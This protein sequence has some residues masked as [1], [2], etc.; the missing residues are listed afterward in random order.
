MKNKLFL[1]IVN[2]KGQGILEVVFSISVVTIGL[3]SIVSLVLFNI[4]VQN[5][6]HN[7]LIAS[8]LAREGIEIVRNVRDSNWLDP[9]K[10]WDDSLFITEE[11]PTIYK[12]DNSFIILTW[13]Q[14]PTPPIESCGYDIVPA[15][16]SWQDCINEKF[17]LGYALCR[18]STIPLYNNPEHK[19]FSQGGYFLE[20]EDTNFYR[21]IYINEICDIFGHEKILTNHQERCQDYG[22]PKI[23]MQIISKVGWNHKGV[24]QTIEAEERLYNWK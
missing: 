4:N 9:A 23:G 8:N 2:K 12:D 18:I 7:I 20:G 1:K 6:N 19:T 5:Y 21:M 15:G 17:D 11:E 22:Y 14:W 13:D 24:V 10:E 16:V 3:I